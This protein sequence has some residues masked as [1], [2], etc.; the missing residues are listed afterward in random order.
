MEP[1]N[2]DKPSYGRYR[3]DAPGEHGQKEV[4]VTLG[5]C[6]DEKEAVLRL[7]KKMTEAGCFSVETVRERIGVNLSFR[8]QAAWY[9]EQ[10]KTGGI[11]SKKSGMPVQPTTVAIYSTAINYLN[12]FVGDLPLASVDNAEAKKLIRL[13]LIDQKAGRFSQS[14]KT[15]REYFQTL[16]LVIASAGIVR[17][18]TSAEPPY[19]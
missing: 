10:L 19:E 18:L 2:P 5:K 17:S 1:W 6:K 7:H 9:L 15:I 14:N 8:R 3:T 16:Q 12:T 13:M 4:R 11:V